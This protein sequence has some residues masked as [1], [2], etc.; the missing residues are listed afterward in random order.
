MRKDA[1]LVV[2]DGTDRQKEA[3]AYSLKLIA[4]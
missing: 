1:I 4:D 2:R 3:E